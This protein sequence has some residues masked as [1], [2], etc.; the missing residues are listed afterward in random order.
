MCTQVSE[1]IQILYLIYLSD[2]ICVSFG[3]TEVTYIVLYESEEKEEENS[4]HSFVG[5]LHV[6]LVPQQRSNLHKMLFL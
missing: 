5:I 3:G 1:E 6:C 2:S 4:S